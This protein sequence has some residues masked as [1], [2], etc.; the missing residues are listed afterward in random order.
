[1]SEDF[2]WGVAYALA[3]SSL[4]AASILASGTFDPA[5]PRR[6]LCA[7]RDYARSGALRRDFAALEAA[8]PEIAQA[9]EGALAVFDVIKNT[10]DRADRDRWASGP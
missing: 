4:G 2:A 1:M 7:A 3:G 8:G 6:Y 9:R 5:W 10:V